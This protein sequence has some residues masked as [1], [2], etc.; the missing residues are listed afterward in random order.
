R[1][2]FARKRPLPAG[3]PGLDIDVG[4]LLPPLGLPGTRRLMVQ[5]LPARLRLAGIAPL[6]HGADHALPGPGADLLA[7]VLPGLGALIW[8]EGARVAGW[9][10]QVSKAGFAPKFHAHARLPAGPEGASRWVL[11]AGPVHAGGKA[12]ALGL[13]LWADQPNHLG[14]MTVSE[15]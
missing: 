3:E 12:F 15:D 2:V 8:R 5:G 9:P 7:R 13:V 6:G 10:P 14:R 1:T 11:A 4:R